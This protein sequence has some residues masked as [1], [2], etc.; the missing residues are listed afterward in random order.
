MKHF[1]VQAN[2]VYKVAFGPEVIPLIG[3]L[4]QFGIALEKFDSGLSFQNPHEF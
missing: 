4:L 1:F 2:C 3:F